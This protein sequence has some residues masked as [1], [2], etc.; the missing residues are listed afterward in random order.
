[1]LTM[2]AVSFVLLHLMLVIKSMSVSDVGIEDNFGIDPSLELPQ[3]PTADNI[4]FLPLDTGAACLDGS[5]YA[6]YFVKGSANSTKWSISIQGGGWCY[7]ETGCYSR[8]KGSLGTSTV[9]PHSSGCGC[10]YYNADGSRQNDCNCVFMRYCDGAS[11][12]GYREHSFPVSQWPPFDNRSHI[13]NNATLYFRGIRNLDATL[14]LLFSKYNLSQ[15]TEM[16]VTGGS[17]GGLSTF[18]HADRISNTLK[19]RIKNVQVRAAPVVG[20]FL[21]HDNEVKS[22]QN[23]TA[24]MKY[25]YTMQNLTSTPDGGLMSACTDYYSKTGDEFKCFMSPHAQA[26]VQTPYF[27]LNSKY[28][29]WQMN[30]ILQ[31]KCAGHA[32]I[33]CNATQQHDVL[34]YGQDFMDQFS[35][36]PIARSGQNG[37]FITSCICHGCPWGNLI[38]QGKTTYQALAEWY[39]SSEDGNVNPHVYID[40]RTPNGDGTLNFSSCVKFP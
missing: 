9:W 32:T 29:A 38:L 26:F 33:I 19:A 22:A 4:V 24:W 18:L 31:S 30:N 1:M 3:K 14:N 36:V 39:K 37:A 21:D 15:A 34:T 25:I 40:S 5:P 12:S 16:M 27:M 11:F 13:P 23:Y 17:A 20:Y 28:D 35:N 6:F 2:P 8:S 7:N 10:M